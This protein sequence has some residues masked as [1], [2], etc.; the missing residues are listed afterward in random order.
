MR[1][2]S[3]VVVALLL[4]VWLGSARP[5]SAG[6]YHV[7]SCRTPAGAVAPTDGWSGSIDGGWMSDPNNC[8]SGGSLTAGLDGE[9]AQPANAADAQWIFSAPAGTQIVAAKLWRSAYARS[10]EPG[11]NSTLS[12]LEAPEDSYS[13]ADV[14]YQCVR[15][16]GCTEEGD[17]GAPMSERKPD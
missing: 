12:A 15:Y 1:S 11:N 8:E 2:F 4:G 17:P 9:V 7:Y 6:V 13:S 10:W 16:E 14:F 5:A 3:I